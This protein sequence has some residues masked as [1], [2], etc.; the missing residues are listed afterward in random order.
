M[1]KSIDNFFNLA[2]KL[3]LSDNVA[4]DWLFEV[5]TVNTICRKCDGR[6]IFECEA[7]VMM[8]SV[9]RQT[10]LEPAV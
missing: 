5:C 1:L 2:L 10:H 7:S 8:R 4:P 3:T 6:H 9:G